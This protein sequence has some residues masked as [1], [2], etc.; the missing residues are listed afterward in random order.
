MRVRYTI[1]GVG[2]GPEVP[3]IAPTVNGP[4]FRNQMRRLRAALPKSWRKLLAFD[5]PQIDATYIAPPPRPAALDTDLAE[6]RVRWRDLLD[7]H[8]GERFASRNGDTPDSIQ[9]MV[10]LLIHYQQL[11]NTVVA[12]QLSESGE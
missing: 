1:P 3:E 12:R 9:R 6:E 10:A 5:E 4:S 11:R 2:P 8:A 7:R